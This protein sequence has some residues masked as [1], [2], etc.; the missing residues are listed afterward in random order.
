ML[1]EALYL[2]QSTNLI[3]LKKSLLITTFCLISSL[4]NTQF[5]ANFD[6]HIDLFKNGWRGQVDHFHS[7][8]LGRLQ[9][10][11][12]KGVQSSLFRHISND[13]SRLLELW[14]TLDFNPSLRNNLDIHL[15]S[16]DPYP[17]SRN[18]LILHVGS[19]GPDD[20]IELILRSNGIETILASGRLGAVAKKPSFRIKC[21]QTADG[22]F[23]LLV[24]YAGGH[25][26]ELEFEL[27]GNINW[28]NR[29][30]FGLVCNYTNSRRDK[31]YF[32]DLVMSD[33][34]VD[35]V[36][37]KINLTE[38][39]NDKI[40]M[41]FNE[42]LDIE[43]VD[44]SDF[45]LRPN[46]IH[47]V[48][49]DVNPLVIKL[50]FDDKL[51][52]GD[53][54]EIHVRDIF[55]LSGNILD[56]TVNF[57]IPFQPSFR[58]LLFNEILFNSENPGAEFV[59]LLN[60]TDSILNLSDLQ[61]IYKQRDSIKLHGSLEPRQVI[62]FTRDAEDL[63]R[64]FPHINPEKVNA[65]SLPNLSNSDGDIQLIVRSPGRQSTIDHLRYYDQWHHPLLK[66]T[67]G[68]SL[69]RISTN[70]N[71]SQ[72]S[73]WHSAS[74]IKRFGTPGLPNSQYNMFQNRSIIITPNTR[75]FSPNNDGYLDLVVFNMSFD[76]PGYILT[77]N[78]FNEF[79]QNVSS[80]LQNEILGT[81]E[82][83][84][85]RGRDKNDKVLAPGLY[86][87]LFKLFHLNGNYHAHKIAVG[88][89]P[90]FD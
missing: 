80:P 14:V 15:W 68:V 16:S 18:A 70:G 28:L 54:Y 71:S 32:D 13:S 63:K 35:H 19:E 30:Y 45:V 46:D 58:Q 42:A 37:P 55:D 57:V 27:S 38:F 47:L 86:M 77:V 26:F 51:E 44:L 67:K 41:H 23:T 87:I 2:I 43:N 59:E 39:R 5:D 82:R 62:A 40:V 81:T 17:E 25:S 20:A 78:I 61:L 84:E 65:I 66:N 50:S 52:Q 72:K 7:D 74:A 56:T 53:S 48:N 75:V 69:E 6:E 31:F 34:R 33:Y 11:S 85:W 49:A 60:P 64:E 83:F 4:A 21:W 29:G 79:G 1:K 36:P 10:K 3:K 88:I 73:T 8:N 76:S 89:S 12:T 9:L 24:D 22:M 90:S